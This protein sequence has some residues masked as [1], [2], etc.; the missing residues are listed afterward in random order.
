MRWFL[1]FLTTTLFAA[2]IKDSLIKGEPGDFIVFE[3]SKIATLVSIHS[4]TDTHLILE[5]ISI[6]S[7]L[8][9]KDWAVFVKNK[10]KEAT[11]H[12]LYEIDLSSDE[13]TECY[14]VTKKTFLPPPSFFY[15]LL[16]LPLFI[17]KEPKKIGPPP[18][19]ESI[20]RR[21]LWA[22]PLIV[23]GVKKRASSFSTF[24]C[25]FP[26]DGGELSGK[27]ITL[28]FVPHFPFP[29]YLEVNDPH[30][31]FKLFSIN[32]GKHLPPSLES[33]PRRYPSFIG[34]LI[35]GPTL[36]TFKLSSPSY[37]HSYTLKAL[38]H[39]TGE[40][41]SIIPSITR[42]GELITLTFSISPLE[43]GHVYTFLAVPDEFP[44]YYAESSTVRL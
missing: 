35:K 33:F 5:E 14:S 17:T 24:T 36:Y 7:H 42:Q 3:Q 40:T 41:L 44:S 15:E 23:E 2:T 16:K 25:H 39:E 6:P 20:D 28:Y 12:L 10:G 31:T 1:L 21:A 37:Y 29:I 30:Y 43:K 34:G 32:M 38:D 22:P 27:P 18:P 8:K 13:I 26:N 9:P 11:S 19:P 4:L